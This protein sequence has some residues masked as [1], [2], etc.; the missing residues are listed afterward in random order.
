MKLAEV[1]ISKAQGLHLNEEINLTTQILPKNH[2]L[3]ND[4]IIMLKRFGFRTLFGAWAEDG[5]VNFNTALGIAAAKI[6]GQN[7]GFHV[8]ERGFCEIAAAADGL[9]EVYSDRIDKFNRFSEYFILNTTAPFQL[10]KKGDIVARLEILTPL[11]PQ[12]ALDD[13][14]ISLSGNI[15]LLNV[16]EL[17]QQRSVLLYT[18]F[19]MDENENVHLSEIAEKLTETYRAFNIDF[20]FEENCRHTVNEIGDSLS[21]LL[22]T[23][24]DVIFIIPAIRNYTAQ[25]VTLN[26]IKSIADNIV[27]SHIP[28]Y[29]GSDLII[30]TK[31]NKKIICLPCNYA[32]LDTPLL[33]NYIKLA[34]V[35]EKLQAYDFSHTSAPIIESI[36]HLKSLSKFVKGKQQNLKNKASVAAVV[37]A[38][39]LSKRIGSNK[40]LAENNDEVMVLRAV[41]AATKSEASPVFVVTGFQAAQIEEK[42]ENLDINIVYNSNYRMG[43]KTSINIGLQSVP[44][45]CDGALLIPAD[46]PNVSAQLLNK[47][48]AKFDKSLDKQLI[49]AA[50]KDT[51]SNPV[52]WSKSL[53]SKADLVAENAGVRPVFLEHADYT[54]DI[55]ATAN[56]LLDVNFI[57][58]LETFKKQD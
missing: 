6:C 1:D 44:D 11:I 17:K 45:F 20:S 25:D 38:A 56:E 48:I 26:A 52:L 41:R 13:L 42:L 29:G 47:M 18:H 28:L 37:L 36:S 35:K 12:D 50:I 10:V 8:D 27:C 21:G 55:K 3:T 49:T 31:K 22:N 39:G 54:T 7:L 57:S 33:E 32:F 9:F 19:Y 30:A 46:M 23:D 24:A 14:V 53:F 15:T 5:D 34:I 58:D 43:L 2:I 40:L 16:A 4:D 51:K